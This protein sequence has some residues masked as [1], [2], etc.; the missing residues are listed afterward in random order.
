M[1]FEDCLILLTFSDNS[2]NNIFGLIN[3]PAFVI[4]RS[5]F[6][7]MVFLYIYYKQ[8]SPPQQ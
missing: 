8:E 4:Q 6:S 2:F 3:Q 5:C 1:A 7:E